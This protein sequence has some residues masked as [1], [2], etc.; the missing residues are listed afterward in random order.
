MNR[1]ICLLCLLLALA[2]VTAQDAPAFPTLA[3]L[4]SITIPTRDRV[5]LARRLRGL[6]VGALPAPPRTPPVYTL[7]ERASFT[8]I[9]TSTRQPRT[10]Q[11]ELRA[12]GDHVA[13]WA[14]LKAPLAD[15]LPRALA[16]GFDERV[17]D[18]VRGL[19][20]SENTPGIDGDPRVHALFASGLGSSTAAYFAADHTYP[21]AVYP[22]SNEREMFFFNLDAIAG[23]PIGLLE[24][25]MA[26]EFQHMI[27]HHVQPNEDT[28][29]NEGM[30]TFTEWAL[31]NA[32]INSGFYFLL[33]PETQL[34]DW[35]EAASARAANYGAAGLFLAY[36]DDRFGRQA[37][38]ELSAH[39]AARAWDS[40]EAIA[41][42]RGASADA[43]FTD[44]LVANLWLGL[45]GEG[46]PAPVR[47]DGES[48]P[49]YATAPTGGALPP[50][51][52]FGA[53]DA[54]PPYSARHYLLE[55]LDGAW[56]TF[57]LDAEA[58]YARLIADD[59]DGAFWASGRA[60]LSE[61]RLT[62]TFDLTGLAN[63]RLTFRAWHDLETEWDY[64]YVMLS[65]NGEHWQAVATDRTTTR[66]PNE[67]GYGPG[68]TGVSGGWFDETID[69]TAYAGG[70]A[71]VRFSMI[72]DD[73]INRPGLAI[74]AV[75]VAHNNG[76]I[77]AAP[78]TAEGWVMTDNRLPLT[79]RA[80]VIA[81]TACSAVVQVADA[82]AGGGPLALTPVPGAQA[83]RVI[84]TPLAPFTTELVGYTLT[85]ALP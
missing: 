12:L 72:T 39:P 80:I 82:P 4:E 21:A 8:V 56:P 60:D 32:P 46:A 57:T 34:T 75:Q 61:T 26:H 67:V 30:S 69:L 84:I 5:D 10:L 41:G 47:L 83:V 19:W 38:V 85:A 52:E 51:A 66:D 11:A 14:E 77:S 40:V 44:W 64:G 27:R 79:L 36:L 74:D 70:P 20:G 73:A 25:V 71:H 65:A 7:G 49:L 54:I 45:A 18:A 28:W 78:P 53:P 13:I 22:P 33:Q 55:G 17:Y 62:Y 58:N 37:M 31:F 23:A 35:A 3:A 29:L 63:P 42:V 15:T 43:V 1:L 9:N 16:E 68:Y 24:T 2:P 59:G 50:T 6:D 76:M 81:F 48:I